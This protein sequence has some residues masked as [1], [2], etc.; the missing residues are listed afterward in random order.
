VKNTTS[1]LVLT[2]ALAGAFLLTG[3]SPVSATP[4]S[5][6]KGAGC[7]VGDAN[8]T[9]YFDASCQTHDVIKVDAAGNF[10]FYAYQ[11]AGQLP[12]DA[13]RPSS[14]IRN[15]FVQ[16]VNSSF[17][18]ICGTVEEAITPSGAYKSSFKIN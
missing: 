6:G 10:A 17:G 2:A 12:P 5:P 16:C 9:Y 13:A 18:L 1:A 15:S 7:F 3:A 11:D 4:A 14:T 8:G